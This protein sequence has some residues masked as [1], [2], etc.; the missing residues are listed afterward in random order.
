MQNLLRQCARGWVPDAQA[1]HAAAQCDCRASRDLH[2]GTPGTR[3]DLHRH[4]ARQIPQL[5]WN[6]YQGELK[7]KCCWLKICVDLMLEFPLTLNAHI[8]FGNYFEISISNENPFLLQEL[9]GVFVL[10]MAISICMLE[11]YL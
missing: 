2:G 3:Q 9:V 8:D 4:Q 10:F 6:K 7:K 1:I 5:D 11:V